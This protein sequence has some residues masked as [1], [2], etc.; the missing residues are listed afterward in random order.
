MDYVKPAFAPPSS[1]FAP[2]WSFLYVLIITSFGF[3]FYKAI[4][5][6][7]PIF[8]VIP[9]ILNLFFNLIFTY[10]QFELNN[11]LLAS[12]DIILVLST[13]IWSMIVVYKHY[14]WVTYIQI[15]YLLWVSFA[16]ILQLSIFY[17]NR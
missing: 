14:K 13:L 15:P 11:M 5:K 7:L 8:V 10:L 6:E 1:W 12:I 3:V 4:K 2:V 9:F 17:L 16:T